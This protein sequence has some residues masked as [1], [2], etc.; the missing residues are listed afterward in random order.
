MIVVS[1]CLP[2]DALSRCVPSYLGFSYIGHRVSL[3]GRS[4]KVQPLLLTLEVGWLLTPAALTLDVGKLLSNVLLRCPCSRHAS[5]PPSQLWL[6]II[7][8]LI[9]PDLVSVIVKELYVC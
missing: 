3:H 4:R 7:Q 6:P 2:S 8:Q 1:V 9:I 5:V